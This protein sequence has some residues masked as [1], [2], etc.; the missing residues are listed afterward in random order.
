M[1]ILDESKITS[2][3]DKQYKII[4]KEWEERE[5]MLKKIVKESSQ[6]IDF[7]MNYDHM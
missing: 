7:E 2:D 4:K 6:F 3:L 5:R 1:S